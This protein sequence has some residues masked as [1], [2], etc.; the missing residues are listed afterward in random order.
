[1]AERERENW[2]GQVR[3]RG[4]G[5]TDD[6]SLRFAT[7]PVVFMAINACGGGAPSARAARRARR[8]PGRH[9]YP[10]SSAA[11]RIGWRGRLGGGERVSKRER[12]G[13]MSTKK[14]F[15][16]AALSFRAVRLTVED[17][18]V[19]AA[20]EGLLARGGLQRDLVLADRQAA[21]GDAGRR[22]HARGLERE[23]HVV[24]FV[25]V[26]GD[27]WTARLCGGRRLQCGE[28]N[29]AG[30]GAPQVGEREREGR[31]GGKGGVASGQ[32]IF[33]SSLSLLSKRGRA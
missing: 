10:A 17:V 9:A 22:G 19:G 31:T 12:E 30:R 18:G 26:G 2:R 23:G 15:G 8:I 29:G 1:L 4:G 6:R 25:E 7:T 27:A 32:W 24:C 5:T 33:V 16:R 11:V 13:A 3:E 14:F 20:L 21:G 28:A